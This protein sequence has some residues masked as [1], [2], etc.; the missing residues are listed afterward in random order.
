PSTVFESV[1]MMLIL[2]SYSEF[3]KNRNYQTNEKPLLP[4]KILARGFNCDPNIQ[5]MNIT[6]HRNANKHTF[7]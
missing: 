4:K 7:S 3:T 6:L 5:P 1:A 2:N